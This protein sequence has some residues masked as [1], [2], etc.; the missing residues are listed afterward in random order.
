MFVAKPLFRQLRPL[1]TTGMASTQIDWY[2]LGKVGKQMRKAS[3]LCTREV[4]DVQVL[5]LDIVSLNSSW[6]PRFY[7]KPYT[8]ICPKPWTL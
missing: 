8:L 6:P 7:A 2:L 4:A 1:G 3:V 5:T